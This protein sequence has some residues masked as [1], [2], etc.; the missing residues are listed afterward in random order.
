LASKASRAALADAQEDA[1]FTGQDGSTGAS[2][3]RVLLDGLR[4]LDGAPDDVKTVLGA[5]WVLVS[6]SA[7]FWAVGK[8]VVAVLEQIYELWNAW[9]RKDHWVGLFVAYCKLVETDLLAA[10][11][12]FH[13]TGQLDQLEKQLQTARQVLETV[14]HRGRY[15]SFLFAQ[16]DEQALAEAQVAIE[17]R[18]KECLFGHAA[19]I[20]AASAENL[21]AV[22]RLADMVRQ[23][24]QRL[25]REAAFPGGLEERGRRMASLARAFGANEMDTPGRV[26]A[27]LGRFVHA[28][29]N[30]WLRAARTRG[31]A[32]AEDTARYVAHHF[33]LH[34]LV[35]SPELD[36]QQTGSAESKAPSDAATA[37]AAGAAQEKALFISLDPSAQTA[38]LGDL[39]SALGA[40]QVE[41]EE[42]LQRAEFNKALARVKQ[43]RSLLASLRALT[44]AKPTAEWCF[45]ACCAGRSG[46]SFDLVGVT[47]ACR[48]SGSRSAAAFFNSLP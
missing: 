18:K 31:D 16:Y 8:V 28:Q 4:A 17:A 38:Q 1:T 44:P 22:Q 47:R 27:L 11:K 40:A 21:D 25:E 46:R 36:V 41:A 2:G 5:G 24:Q 48:S 45:R 26:E 30:H 20:K 29:R 14:V 6:E 42:M 12:V 19:D 7:K 23:R 33:V 15:A 10:Q 34:G 43:A 9:E 13:S 39:R 35:H 32:G 3:A 37:A